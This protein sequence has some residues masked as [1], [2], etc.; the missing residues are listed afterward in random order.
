MFFVLDENNNKVEAFDKKGVLNA[1]NTAIKDG[2]LANLVADAAFVSK[3]KCCVSGKTNKTAF[4][5]QEKYNELAA[6]GLLERN[7]LYYITDD[8]WA[9]GVD[10][11]LTKISDRLEEVDEALTKTK[12]IVNEVLESQEKITATGGKVQITKAG[13]YLVIA[14]VNH[15]NQDL[16]YSGIITVPELATIKGVAK[17]QYDNDYLFLSYDVDQPNEHI[18]DLINHYITVWIKEAERSNQTINAYR[19]RGFSI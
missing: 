4:V 7:T 11:A 14:R 18:P 12:D 9:D 1:L 15:N 8:T 3:L 16:C 2:S 13:V 19:L 17:Y 6:A 10:E 5:T